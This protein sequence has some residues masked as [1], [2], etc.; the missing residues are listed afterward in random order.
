MIRRPP[1]STLFPYTTLFRSPS[2]PHRRWLLLESQLPV[3][4][5]ISLQHQLLEERV[6]KQRQYVLANTRARWGFVGFGMVLLAAVKLAGITTIS[7]WFILDFAASFAAADTGM[8]RL[9]QGGAFE[10]WDAQLNIG[11]GPL[12]T[13]ALPFAVGPNR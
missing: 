2:V 9:V 3:P 4:P 1:R 6:A 5:V 13:S 7:W 12:L 8:R 10:P 11:L